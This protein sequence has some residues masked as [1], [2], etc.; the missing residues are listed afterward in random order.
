MNVSD[1]QPRRGD[2]IVFRT[3]L[4][5]CK[6]HKGTDMQLRQE[7]QSGRYTVVATKKLS[8]RCKARFEL[9]AAFPRATF[10]AIWPKQDDDHRQGRSKPRTIVTH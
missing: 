6:G 5:R 1:R 10:K 3:R 9:R 4:E 7:Q 8:R 2:Q